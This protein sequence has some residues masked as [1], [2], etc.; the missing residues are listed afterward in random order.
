[1]TDRNHERE[2]G[3][4][5]D[6]QRIARQDGQ[7]QW[8]PPTRPW[9]IRQTWRQLLF[10][11]WPVSPAVL[12]PRI[13]AGLDLETFGGDAWIG[14]VP[15]ELGGLSANRLTGRAQLTFPELN[16]RTYV[17]VHDKPGVWF[18]SLDA[19]SLLAVRGARA[20]YRLPYFWATMQM[21]EQDGWVTFRSQR[22]GDGSTRFATRYRP[23]GAEFE[24]APGSLERW[25]TARYCLYATS[26]GGH[27]LRADI[28]HDP[29]LLQPADAEITVNTMASVQGITLEGPPLLHF[30]GRT[31]MVAW[32]VER[33]R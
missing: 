6:W 8:A 26:R 24:S 9:V 25:L 31:D 33:V 10:A 4:L 30:A 23:T 29:W 12:R 7:R 2:P 14:I 18:F 22:R 17:S 1:M 28:N 16:V 19:A 3:P 32:G 21:T 15:F 20:T 27:I 13:P 5:P 11:H